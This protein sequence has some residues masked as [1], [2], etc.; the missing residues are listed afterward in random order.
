[1]RL[2]RRGITYEEL[3]ALAEFFIIDPIAAHSHLAIVHSHCGRQ[4]KGT[5]IPLAKCYTGTLAC[6]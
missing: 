6:C 5:N 2:L 3:R 4:M 1:V